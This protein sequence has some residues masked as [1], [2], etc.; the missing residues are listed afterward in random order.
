[1]SSGSRP[2]RRND[3]GSGRERWTRR[4][5]GIAP[6]VHARLLRPHAEP[7]RRSQPLRHPPHGECKR[8]VGGWGK[9]SFLYQGRHDA[10]CS[11]EAGGGPARTGGHSR[12]D[13]RAVSSRWREPSAALRLPG[14]PALR[15]FG[16]AS[17]STCTGS[18]PGSP[19]PAT[20]RSFLSQ[21]SPG[22]S[23]AAPLVAVSPRSLAS[24]CAPSGLS[25]SRSRSRSHV[26]SD[27]H[28]TCGRSRSGCRSCW[29]RIC[30]SAAGSSPT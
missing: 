1:M 22:C 26:A 3:R 24:G 14:S 9:R 11:R 28:R 7:P 19:S 29:P 12:C 17:A 5:R 15:R 23:P 18:R 16:R 27:R 6:P 2:P 10:L 8:G 25:P 4:G 20:W 21:P 13:Q 30:S